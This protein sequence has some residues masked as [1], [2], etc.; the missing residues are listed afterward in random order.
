MNYTGK[1][2]CLQMVVGR[3]PT[4]L[5]LR[6]DEGAIIQLL[7]NLFYQEFLNQTIETFLSVIATLRYQLCDMTSFKNKR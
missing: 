7:T 5:K 2:D 6:R 3:I 1:E 4:S